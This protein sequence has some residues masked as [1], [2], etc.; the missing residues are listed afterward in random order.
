MTKIIIYI[1]IVPLVIW[2]C[3]SLNINSIFKKNRE[4]QARIFYMFLVFGLSYLV[5]SF[6]SDFI[7]VMN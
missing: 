1:F 5:V 4:Y 2:S 6:L 3:D 7:G